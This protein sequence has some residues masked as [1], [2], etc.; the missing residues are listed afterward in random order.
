MGGLLFLILAHQIYEDYEVLRLCHVLCT[1]V[2]PSAKS[3]EKVLTAW[4]QQTHPP[5]PP[6][7]HDPSCCNS[8]YSSSE[9]TWWYFPAHSISIVSLSFPHTLTMHRPRGA[10]DYSPRDLMTISRG[11]RKK[12]SL[13]WQ[14]FT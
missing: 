7:P 8:F 6:P 11:G 14:R 9:P 12:G 5:L 10:K 4:R 13:I 3:K 2:K 1:G